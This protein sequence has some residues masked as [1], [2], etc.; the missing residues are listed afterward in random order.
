[1]NVLFVTNVAAPYRVDFF[2]NIGTYCNL[3]VIYEMDR[4]DGRNE[5]WIGKN[6]ETYQSILLHGKSFY[7]QDT[8]LNVK[9]IEILSKTKYDVTIFG[10]STSPTQMLAILYM[11]WKKMPYII[12]DDGLFAPINKNIIYFCNIL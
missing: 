4:V 1:M 2:N 12:S 7:H 8:T 11:Q 9:L 5:K 6:A 10:V 3:T